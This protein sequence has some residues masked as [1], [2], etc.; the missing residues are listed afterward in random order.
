MVNVS[1][2][3]LSVLFNLQLQVVK[4]ISEC[5]VKYKRTTQSSLLS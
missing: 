3:V 1:E 4:I 2:H 5:Y